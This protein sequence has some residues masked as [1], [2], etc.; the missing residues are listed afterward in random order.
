MPQVSRPDCIMNA[1]FILRLEIGYTINIP[2]NRYTL[3]STHTQKKDFVIC[4]L[5]V[6]M[7][8]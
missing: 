8:S 6:F 2:T 5:L 1:L 4:E 7:D 3:K